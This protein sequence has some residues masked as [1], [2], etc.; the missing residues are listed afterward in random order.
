MKLEEFETSVRRDTQPPAGLSAPLQA[1]WHERRGEWHEAHKLV[2]EA[3]TP[4]ENWIH[5]YLH[6]VAGDEDKAAYWYARASKVR[7]HLPFESEW[8]QIVAALL[9]SS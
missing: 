4:N 9:P 5:A 1:L 8:R 7:P 3:E 6:R 2:R